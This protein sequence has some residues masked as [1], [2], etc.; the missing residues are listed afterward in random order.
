MS[1]MVSRSPLSSPALQVPTS[2][3]MRSSGSAGRISPPIRSRGSSSSSTNFPKDPAAR[4]SNAR[5]C[6]CS[7]RAPR[8]AETDGHHRRQAVAGGTVRIRTPARPMEEAQQLPPI[9]RYA[10]IR[11]ARLLTRLHHQPLQRWIDR[12]HRPHP[13]RGL[14]PSEA[15]PLRN[16]RRYALRRR[17]AVRS[18]PARAL[19]R[20][21]GHCL[22]SLHPPQ[23]VPKRGVLILQSENDS[24]ASEIRARVNQ[25]RHTP[26]TSNIL[27]PDPPRPAL[28]AHRRHEAAS[29]VLPQRLH[30]DT[31]QLRNMR[32]REQAPTRR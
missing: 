3:Q 12:Q 14:F 15:Q 23:F 27:A 9:A 25:L 29:L 4:S 8:H 6:A 30:P 18:S 7:P 2:A 16:R 22:P 13:P 20:R 31:G 17:R 24:Y 19:R 32:N 26:Q 1:S 11:S 21:G 10:A 5:S 28:T